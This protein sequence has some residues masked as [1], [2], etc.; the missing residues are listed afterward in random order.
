MIR[1]ARDRTDDASVPIR[2]DSDWFERARQAMEAAKRE[3]GDHQPRPDVY[4]HPLV[5]AA[6]EKLFYDKC[7][8]CEEWAEREASSRWRTRQAVR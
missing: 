4:G 3:G 2:P 7:A 8:Y 5:R 1:I 6:L